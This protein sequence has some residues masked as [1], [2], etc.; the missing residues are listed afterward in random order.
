MF[1]ASRQLADLIKAVDPEGLAL[2]LNRGDG[3]WPWGINLRTT[4]FSS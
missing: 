3:D 1:A 4:G 2:H